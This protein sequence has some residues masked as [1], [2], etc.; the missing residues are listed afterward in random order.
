MFE[1]SPEGWGFLNGF[2]ADLDY[3]G[4]ETVVD[5]F[6]AI[7]LSAES[8]NTL[9]QAISRITLTAEEE[10]LENIAKGL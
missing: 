7:G 3:T 9:L 4:M 2:F 10:Q 6:N 1:A 8:Q 5:L